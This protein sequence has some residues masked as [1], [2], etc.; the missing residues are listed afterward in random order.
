V[1]GITAHST[2]PLSEFAELFEIVV[3]PLIF[4]PF[5]CTLFRVFGLLL[6][7]LVPAVLQLFTDAFYK[8]VFPAFSWS[9]GMFQTDPS[10]GCSD[11][12]CLPI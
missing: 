6:I 4:V 9:Q 3:S 5:A 11:S 2:V 12:R 10:M 1:A 7:C 8:C